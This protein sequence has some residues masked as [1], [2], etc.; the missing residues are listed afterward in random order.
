MREEYFSSLL[1]Q[2]ISYFDRVNQG[3]MATSVIESTTIIQDGIGEK[4]AIGI[5]SLFA[6]I[7]GFTVA[8]YYAWKLTLLLL[9]VIPVM[10]GIAAGAAS[11]LPASTADT[12]NK[13]GSAAQEVLGSIRTVF[14]FNAEDAET[15]RYSSSVKAAQKEGERKGYLTG[16]VVGLFIMVMWLT[17]ALGLWFGSK[18][19]ADDM[20]RSQDCQYYL[21]SNGSLH[22]PDSS[23]CVTGGNVMIAFF[24]IL[25]GGLNLAQAVP[26]VTAIISAKTEL[27]KILNILAIKAT[28][29]DVHADTLVA[30]KTISVVTGK[31]ELKNVA[32]A[33]PSRLDRPVYNDLSLTIEAGSTVALVGASGCGK[34]TLVSL[35][36]RFYDVD[37]GSVLLDGEDIRSLS[38]AWLRQQIGLVSQEPVLFSGSIADNIRYGKP[39]AS[40]EEVERAAKQANAHSFIT[41]FSEGYE[42]QVGERGVQLSGGQ[43]QRIAIARAIVRDPRI[44]ILDEATSA[45]DTASEA[46]V[47]AALD[48]LVKQ[49][50]RTTIIIAHRLS[51][52][53]NA[54]KII[55]FNEGVV[56]ET[57]THDELSSTQG[58]YYN[59][60]SVQSKSLVDE[61]SE[62]IVTSLIRKN[63]SSSIKSEQH[64]ALHTNVTVN[65]SDGIELEDLEKG[66]AKVHLVDSH[67]ITEEDS[68]SITQW[69]WSLTRPERPYLLCG[70]SGAI[71]N[72][73]A[74]PLLGYFLSSMI[75][76]FF[77]TSAPAM[78]REASFWAYLFIGMA[79]LQAFSNFT[80]FYSFNVI[81]ERLASRIRQRTFSKLLTFD[82]AWFDQPQH[83]AGSLAQRL[84]SD[85]VQIKALTGE[86]AATTTSQS[87]TLV[88]ALAIAFT[89][90]WKMSLIM[91]GLF[92][93]IGMAFG[94]QISA[95]Q[96][97]ALGVT[98]ATNLAGSIASQA[99]LNI[100]TVVAFNLET[101]SKDNFA[102][103][104][105]LPLSSS[106][107]R[108]VVTGLGMGFAQFIILAGAGLAY[109]A[110][111]ALIRDGSLTFS[112]LMSVILSIMFGAVGLGQLAADASDK[113]VAMSAAKNI[114]ELW[115]NTSNDN[116][117]DLKTLSLKTQTIG[118]IELK[119]VAFAYPSRPEHKVCSDLSLTIE[120]GSTVAL[121][122]ASGCG[123]ST[124]VSLLE[125]FYDV[126][127][128][129]VLLDG[130]DIRS[131][132]VAWLRQQ[133]GLVSQEPV[134]FSGS[135][136]D[137]IRYGKPDAS[138]EE[139]E[140]AA[141][142][143]NAHS[144]ITAFSEG[145]ETQ[146][147]ERGV[148]LSGGQKQRI[149]IARA[150]V[151]DPRILILD[152]AT[153]A[154]DTASEA[155]VQAALDDIVKQ[156][157]RTTIIIAHRLST[158]R[159][160]DKIIVLERGKMVEQGTHDELIS[161]AD[162]YYN[163]LNTSATHHRCST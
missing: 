140:R 78:R 54:D 96:K 134:L 82:V 135:I 106:I 73:A 22:S 129:S 57:G 79:V 41:G 152:E 126:D 95:V 104:L 4:L 9:A 118:N 94:I 38:V 113:T 32:F 36:E 12:Y 70:V 97:A 24:C 125:R 86:R 119:N 51:T 141:K 122:G 154:L 68:L 61:A 52:I 155:V 17:Y 132:S 28:I 133:I 83:T 7:A 45:L 101:Q 35:L 130:E 50:S 18:L 23:V 161:L 131:L 30:L 124:L 76:A 110:G 112:E 14:A 10:I 25:F 88:V 47:Q 163:K 100:R 87:V 69:L 77:N 75:S 114:K 27:S 147:G 139:V 15:K 42:T 121:V 128:G 109:Y 11:Y 34:S 143:A 145:Y 6:F 98:D 40:I 31:I 93:L 148:Q 151:R 162:G 111:G 92:P 16:I 49:R 115:D 90:S 72:G 33:Y 142:Q 1:S 127:S 81:T 158:I 43:K 107:K 37:S 2:D 13:A 91:L 21:T 160:A 60:L 26:A 105:L 159:N 117:K 138:I 56:V 153:S 150:I 3:E 39:D 137:N 144:F 29:A 89:H 8:L 123:K 156:R 149:A 103:S 67:P 19:I 46:V 5:Q 71:V 53:R 74:F 44:L 64:T 80:S 99:I 102:E 63:S 65:V 136:A 157:S 66:T 59:L 84:S 146:V 20:E 116:T 58:L 55:C 108:G 120:A 48:E 85:S 62:S